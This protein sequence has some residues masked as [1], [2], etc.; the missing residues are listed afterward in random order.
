M[1]N[2]QPII[3]VTEAAVSHIENKI[4]ERGS[5]YFHLAVKEAGCTG[6]KYLMDIIDE[7]KPGDLKITQNGFSFFIDSDPNCLK[8]INGS[9]LDFVE[10][11]LGQRQLAVNNPNVTGACGCGESFYVEEE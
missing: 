11:G 1:S 2:T 7:P 10:K 4:T 5:G 9:V 6:Y 8:I 3:S